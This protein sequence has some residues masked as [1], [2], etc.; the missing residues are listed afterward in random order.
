VDT[1][2]AVHRLSS[3]CKLRRALMLPL[4]ALPAADCS[5][6]NS[7]RTFFFANRSS[8]MIFEYVS[9]VLTAAVETLAARA[10]IRCALV[11]A[12]VPPLLF[13]ALGVTK[14]AAAERSCLRLAAAEGE[15]DTFA[16]DGRAVPL[17]TLAPSPVSPFRG[18]VTLLD[19]ALTVAAVLKEARVRDPAV[20]GRLEPL[21]GSFRVAVEELPPSTGPPRFAS[22]DALAG[23]EVPATPPVRFRRPLN[24]VALVC[25]TSPAPGV[26]YWIRR[27]PCGLLGN[28]GLLYT[29]I[30][31]GRVVAALDFR[32]P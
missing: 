12:L 24:A 30:G 28:A 17:F 7:T 19:A 22:G 8:R 10:A 1:V 15:L 29:G 6:S 5:S 20:C 3:S 9:V 25:G 21:G 26:R 16:V 14:E 32:L 31:A 18:V 23:I 13:K 2:L 11:G 4:L 27:L